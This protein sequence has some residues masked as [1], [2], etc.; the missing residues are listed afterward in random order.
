MNDV[1]LDNKRRSFNL[2]NLFLDPNN[3]RFVDN[4]D[5]IKVNEEK[6]LDERIQKRT[7]SFI[8]GNKRDN[9]A[10]LI[11]SF[12]ANGFLDVD[13][14]QARDLGSNNYL[15][16]EGNRRVTALK[17]LQEDNENGL[18]IGSLNPNI[19]RSIPFEIHAN[20]ETEKHL[21]IMGLKHISGNKKWS[22]INQAQLIYDYL[23]QYWQTEEYYEK[24]KDLCDSL[25]IS[26]VK[27][28][29]SQRAY[30]LILSYKNSDYGDQFKSSDFSLFSEIISRPS[31]KEWIDWDDDLYNAKNTSNR[32]RLFSWLS[33]TEEFGD[34]G[35]DAYI[36]PIISKSAEIRDLGVFI[37]NEMAINE[38]EKYRSVSRGLLASGEIDK[39][40]YEKVVNNVIDG[41]DKLRNYFDFLIEDEASFDKLKNKYSELSPN[42]T[43]L[44]MA[45]GNYSTCFEYGDDI[46]QFD[47]I[48]IQKYKI[49]DSF[50]ID[51]LRKI[52]I[53]T[54]LNNA[55]KT[56]ILEAIYYLTKQNDIV[57]FLELIKL[58]N[59]LDS[60]NPLWLNKVFNAEDEISVSGTFNN[61]NTTIRFRKFEARNID[62]KNDYIASYNLTAQ[63]D[64]RE[65]SNI[66][67]TFQYDTVK[68]ENEKVEHLCNSRFK[69]P[70]FYNTREIIDT[71]N[72]N[73]QIKSNDLT[74]INQVIKFVKE[75]DENINDIRLN[76][77]YGVERFIVDSSRFSN[78]N[79]EITNYGE[80][81]QRV[82]EIALAFAASR[83]GIVCIDE[84]ETAI[85][86]SLL[87]KFTKFIQELADIFNVQV[88]IT[89]HSK[90]CIDAFVNNGYKNEDISA[91]FLEN[92]NNQMSTKYI[93]GERLQYLVD[94][95]D[96]DI[97]GTI[98][99]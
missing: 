32:N 36:E 38:M 61:K 5:Y 42:G 65:L 46:K 75:I 22:A 27:L 80:G 62:K 59:K 60:L 15:V 87:L 54:G 83:N 52:N 43:N 90:E 79:I 77:D 53:F 48:L 34:D 55:G 25:G 82:F 45:Y 70:Y 17:A 21:I 16:I 64:D 96:L 74:A 9:I 85:H 94:S 86:Y 63:I 58:K 84:F 68:R 14:I 8:E 39:Q 23:K 31:I 24:E 26:K 41:L 35:D 95:I 91:Y 81:L 47:E 29:T 33:R 51:R 18:D 93:G 89:T 30:H 1:V 28:R 56:S 2:K 67:H 73:T 10:D 57:S 78:R 37:K 7:R 20:E 4:R 40:N 97:R 66:I 88:F 72:K 50:R 98:N 13:V 99:E 44:N 49:F 69:S 12:K 6:I 3:Y 11:S 19:F 76:D 71:Y 92:T